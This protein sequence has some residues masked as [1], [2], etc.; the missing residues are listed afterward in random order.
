M[1]VSEMSKEVAGRKTLLIS[2]GRCRWWNL[3]H[4]LSLYSK[5]CPN[6]IDTWFKSI[7]SKKYLL[8]ENVMKEKLLFIIRPNYNLKMCFFMSK[9][10]QFTLIF[11]VK[12]H[13][14]GSKWIFIMSPKLLWD[15][16]F[17]LWVYV[18]HC[19]IKFID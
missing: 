3:K 17:T 11:T 18:T 13:Q 6:R 15:K 19:K 9:S 1:I 4:W 8:S 16:S 7:I 2:T 12:R 10:I 5:V 14:I